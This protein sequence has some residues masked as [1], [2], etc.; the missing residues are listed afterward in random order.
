MRSDLRRP[1]Y[2]VGVVD[3]CDTAFGDMANE[4]VVCGEWLSD[5]RRGRPSREARGL[6]FGLRKVPMQMLDI[7]TEDIRT[8]IAV[9]YLGARKARCRSGRCGR[10]GGWLVRRGLEGMKGGALSK[11]TRVRCGLVV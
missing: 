8:S 5:V 2:R 7:G 4:V 3:Y 6:V 10:R 1:R 9:R 11:A